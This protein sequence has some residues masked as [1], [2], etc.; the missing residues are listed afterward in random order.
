[1]Y[2]IRSNNAATVI[3]IVII[4]IAFNIQIHALNKNSHISRSTYHTLKELSPLLSTCSFYSN[5]RTDFRTSSTD[6]KVSSTLNSVVNTKT[7]KRFSLAFTKRE[8]FYLL[9]HS[10]K[11]YSLSTELKLPSVVISTT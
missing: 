2:R 6:S 7:G 11:F 9:D 1:M 5:V 8:C 10:Y 3:I 4:T